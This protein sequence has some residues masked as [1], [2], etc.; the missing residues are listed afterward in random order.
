MSDGYMG[1]LLGPA[2]ALLYCVLAIPIARLADTAS[3]VMI[4]CAGCA[5]W[6]FFTILSGWAETPTMLALA[7]IGVGVGEAAYQAPGAALVAAYFPVEQRGKAFAIMGSAVYFG[8]MLGLVG[9]PAIAAD[10]G[11]RTAFEVV[12]TIG[13]VTALIAFLIIREPKRQ[14]AAQATPQI[15]L[16]ILF[17]RL[18]ARPSFR[19]MTIG[20]A[21]GSLSGVSFG[22]WGPALF[23]RVHDVPTEMASSTFGLAFGLPG[24][25]GMLLFGFVADRFAR[26]GPGWLLGLSAGALFAATLLILLVTWAPN[27]AVAR[28]LAIPSG[29]LGSGW[30]IGIIAGLQFVLPERFRVSGTALALLIIG[31]AGN[32]VGPLAAGQL[33]DIFDGTPARSLQF[34]LTMIIPSGFL[35]AWFMWQAGRTIADDQ[36]LLQA[37][38]LKEAFQ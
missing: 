35:G 9:G 31:L 12:G 29:L 17:Q 14:V 15:P 25:G 2:F 19:R 11:W 5:V 21:L 6:S 27:I 8:Q 34:G 33:S 7:R 37:D 32:V 36:Q 23:E 13:L 38:N 24:L 20:M 18:W 16:V 28:G 22:M 3:R 26:K 30:S 1:L 10:H 4:V